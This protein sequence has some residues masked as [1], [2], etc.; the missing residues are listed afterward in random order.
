MEISAPT[1]SQTR[2]A[3]QGKSC[4]DCGNGNDDK[5]NARR[6]GEL[7]EDEQKRV[8]D[9]KAR[10][11]EVRAHEAAHLAAA[12]GYAQ[13]GANFSYSRGPDGMLYATG[14]EVSIDS[15]AVAGD[16]EATLRK[17]QVVQRAA[18]A[19]AEPSGQDR[20]VAAEAAAMA[21]QARQEI[22]SAP[23]EETARGENGR[24]EQ[25][26]GT[27]TGLRERIQATGGLERQS[28]STLHLIA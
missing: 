5:T 18:L 19:P 26:A 27:A 23:A 12:G 21:T 20:Q 28:P 14:G 4:G 13:G 16:P 9:L 10:D 6:P 7:P 17:A 2:P 25:A 15:S 8:Q 1:L 22:A 3:P 24:D 11:R